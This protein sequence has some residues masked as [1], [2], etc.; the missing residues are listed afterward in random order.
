MILLRVRSN[1]L[2]N[3]DSM[4]HLRNIKYQKLSLLILS[5]KT[6]RVQP[7]LCRKTNLYSQIRV[8]RGKGETSNRLKSGLNR[9]LS[10]RTPTMPEYL[11]GQGHP[12]DVEIRLVRD[13]WMICHHPRSR[14]WSIQD[15][16]QGWMCSHSNPH[17]TRDLHM[18]TNIRREEVNLIIG[19][20]TFG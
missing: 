5:L 9:S 15:Q 8:V 13:N 18:I 6:H 12:M 3:L 4:F 11:S 10:T 7:R 14:L 2:L 1:L 20:R 16:S 19:F 17:M